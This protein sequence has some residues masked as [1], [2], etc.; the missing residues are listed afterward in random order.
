MGHLV[1]SRKPPAPKELPEH[2]TTPWLGVCAQVGEYVNRI[3]KRNNLEAAVAPG[4]GAGNAACYYAHASRIEVDAERML[5][6]T[7][8]EHVLV[9]DEKF[10]LRHSPFMGAIAHE[11]G[12]ARWT[13]LMPWDIMQ[14]Y[15]DESA[16]ILDVFMLLEESRIESKLVREQPLSRKYIKAAVGQILL[17]DFKLSG[18]K[19]GAASAAALLLARVNAGVFKATD[20]NPVREKIGEVLSEKELADLQKLWIEFHRLNPSKALGEKCPD[21]RRGIEICHE[22]LEVLD[23]PAEDPTENL[24]IIFVI[25]PDAQDEG[26]DQDGDQQGM[27]G[28][29]GEFDED[30]KDSAQGSSMDAERDNIR[31]ASDIESRE[32]EE[33]AEN[34]KK[35]AERAKKTAVKVFPKVEK[36]SDRNETDDDFEPAHGP[37]YSGTAHLRV[38]RDPTPDERR[39]AQALAR[40]LEKAQYRDRVVVRRNSS[41]PPGRYRGRAGILQT[42]QEERDLPETAEPWRRKQRTHV[43]EP[44]LIVG[45]GQ[46][47]SGSMRRAE[48]P[49]ASL[50]WIMSHAVERV[51]GKSATVVYGEQVYGV[52]PQGARY[53]KVN[54]YA[55]TD[56]HENFRDAFDALDGEL[57]FLNATGARMLVFFS[58]GHYG[59]PEYS[60]YA[61]RA[62]AWCKERGVA[63][64]WV[65]VSGSFNHNHGWGEIVHV[66]GLEPVEA[67][68]AIGRMAVDA[69]ATASAV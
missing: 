48:E 15:P 24:S 29:S 26:Q 27:G 49:C 6:G 37:G 62:M 64:V 18:D 61:D 39:A 12:H 36:A 32:K 47:I 20:M 10:R 53:D 55:A 45:E 67:A 69:L 31:S 3:A 38:T 2:V 35:R 34:E 11:A 54:V 52:V 19:Y 57:G 50:A 65:D 8:P 14:L 51:H 43:D 23:I 41:R 16:R 13:E 22:W 1:A 30:I 7:P 33:A 68:I 21:L 56:G 44:Q 42:V 28:G 5:D 40:E 25:D 59:I 4:Y 17:Q 46:D 60:E 9:S 58:D 66:G 63:V